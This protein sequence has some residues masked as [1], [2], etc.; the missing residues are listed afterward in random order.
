MP[1]ALDTEIISAVRGGNFRAG[2][3]QLDEV[4]GATRQVGMQAEHPLPPGWRRSG[5][6]RVIDYLRSQPAKPRPVRVRYRQSLEDVVKRAADSL[7][8]KGKALNLGRFNPLPKGRPLTRKEKI[9][10]LA[11]VAAFSLAV[12]IHARPEPVSA[13]AGY[14]QSLAMTTS[15]DAPSVPAFA[16]STLQA[17]GKQW[18][19]PALFA[20]AHPLF[21]QRIPATS[22][23][24]LVKRVEA[25]LTA[26]AA[27]G[28]VVSVTVFGVPALDTM[29]SD[30]GPAVVTSRVEGQVELSDGTVV[31]LKARLIQDEKSGQWGVAELTLPPFLP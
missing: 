2:N 9:S 19:A 12:W 1:P 3:H 30:Q 13:H 26:L 7:D 18:A 31:R 29:E 6:T 15:A 23:D 20:R 22:P 27:H 16:V 5:E 24:A 28:P 10:G 8:R 21:W 17:I 14:F 25:G 4:H 11:L